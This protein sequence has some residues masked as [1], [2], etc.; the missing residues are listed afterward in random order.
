MY[1]RIHSGNG[2]TCKGHH[3]QQAHDI[4][5]KLVTKYCAVLD[6]VEYCK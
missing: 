2:S 6:Q 3:D 4:A 1:L 5:K